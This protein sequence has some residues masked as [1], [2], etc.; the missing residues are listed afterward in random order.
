MK[1]LLLSALVALTAFSCSSDD[2]SLVQ[3]PEGPNTPG[4]NEPEYATDATEY[5]IPVVFHVFYTQKRDSIEYVK[6]G[7]LPQVLEAVNR[8]FANC[9]VDLKL[10]FKLA[11]TDPQGNV[12]EEPGVDRQ[13]VRI[14][15]LSSSEFLK[16]STYAHYMWDQ[17]KYLN[18]CLFKEKNKAVLGISSFP[19]TLHPDTLAGMPKLM[20]MRPASE[21]NY[22]HC[23]Y[24]NAQYIYDLEP[25]N[26]KTSEIV[27]SLCHEI[28]HYLGLRHAFGEDPVTLSRDCDI[29]TDFC[30]DT[31]TYNKSKYDSYLLNNYPYDGIFTD[32]L[33]EQLAWRTNSVTGERFVSH[34][35]MDY[36]V[37]YLDELTPQQCERIRY[38]LMRSP[39]VPGPKVKRDNTPTTAP[40]RSVGTKQPFPHRIAY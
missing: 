27:G 15:T 2:E 6:E 22:P 32:E 16:D 33:V 35:I 8:R 23:V 1:K 25:E 14:G 18:I 17:T 19:Y 13:K 26:Y 34:N 11:E 3:L 40:A 28:A 12:M 21:L 38:I 36:A 31:P 9:G 39:Y 4:G 29:D 20:E 30:E 10:Q 7:H 24:V 37:S 5:E